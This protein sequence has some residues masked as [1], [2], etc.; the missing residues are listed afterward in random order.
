MH[1][2]YFYFSCYRIR[3]TGSAALDLAM[4]ASGAADAF[5]AF[6]IHIWDAAAGELLVT[7]AGG[8]MIDPSGGQVDRLSQRFLVASSQ[9][10]A[11][12]LAKNLTQ[13]FSEDRD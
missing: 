10:L 12:N 5:F 1:I 7:E 8:V 2:L 4:V 9:E 11:Q 3:T 13:Y 6:G